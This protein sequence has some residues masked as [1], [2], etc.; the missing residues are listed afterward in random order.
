MQ[1]AKFTDAMTA[2]QLAVAILNEDKERN[3]AMLK[4]RV[5]DA[6]GLNSIAPDA[7]EGVD[8]K[9]EAKAKEDAETKAVIE[10]GKRGFEGHN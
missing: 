9:A 7:N 4:N 5:A 3:A 1:K 10:A 8:P 6:E 2:E